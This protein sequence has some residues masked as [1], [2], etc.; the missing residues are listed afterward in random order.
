MVDVFV[1]KI[2]WLEVEIVGCEL[3]YF[4]L[5]NVVVVEQIQIEWLFYVVW[6]SDF[7]SL[8]FVVV[9]CMVQVQCIVVEVEV[10]Y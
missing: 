10:I 8:I 2:V 4:V 9:V 5:C 6:M 7:V 1:V 3:V